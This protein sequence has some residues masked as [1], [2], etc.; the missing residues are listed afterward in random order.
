MSTELL[1]KQATDLMNNQD[2]IAS[3]FE[4]A[5][6]LLTQAL[7][8]TTSKADVY[9]NRAV[10]YLNLNK[11][12]LAIFDFNKL[13]EIDSNN[14]FYYSCRGFAKARTQDKKGAILDYEKALEIDPNN[15]ITYNN[16]GLV[17]E[18]IGYLKQ[19][20]KSFA[21]SDDLRKKE[22]ANQIL[23]SKNSEIIKTEVENRLDKS[24]EITGEKESII[25]PKSEE[26]PQSKVEL[27]KDIFTSKSTFKEFINFIKNGFKLK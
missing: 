4:K 13:V 2:A 7:N 16:M 14:A 26:K 20:Q 27:A 22:E 8:D 19:A 10:A 6:D 17:Q 24:K 11:I 25:K 15:P 12:D 9:Y 1:I 21:Q 18:E 5:V 23:Q 3:D